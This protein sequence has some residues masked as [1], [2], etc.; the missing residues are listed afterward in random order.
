MKL[1]TDPDG[2]DIDAGKSSYQ[3]NLQT[4]TLTLCGKSKTYFDSAHAVRK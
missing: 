2:K 4:K 3:I 1:P